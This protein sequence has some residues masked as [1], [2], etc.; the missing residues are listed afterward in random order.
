MDVSVAG[1]ADA[2]AVGRA[3]DGVGGGRVGTAEILD[4]SSGV[5]YVIRIYMPYSH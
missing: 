3:E 4:G 1:R 5:V 2:A